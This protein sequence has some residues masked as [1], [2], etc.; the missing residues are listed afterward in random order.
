MATFVVAALPWF[1][2]RSH[3]FNVRIVIVHDN[4]CIASLALLVLGV[5]WVGRARVVWVVCVFGPALLIA[6]V[7]CRFAVFYDDDLTGI[8]VFLA[9]GS[10]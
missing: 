1:A 8:A 6:A 10:A 2:F 3:R 9:G 7:A 4:H 5:A